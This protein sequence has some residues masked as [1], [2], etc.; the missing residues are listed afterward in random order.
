METPKVSPTS[1]K[2]LLVLVIIL[3]GSLVA[4]SLFIMHGLQLAVRFSR[5]GRFDSRLWRSWILDGILQ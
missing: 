3:A 4:F 5:P 1:L 2:G